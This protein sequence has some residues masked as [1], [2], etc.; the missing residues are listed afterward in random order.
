MF[1]AWGGGAQ[2]WRRTRRAASAGP[3]TPRR[4]RG[5]CSQ[6]FGSGGGRASRSRPYRRTSTRRL[7]YVWPARAPARDSAKAHKPLAFRCDPQTDDGSPRQ[8]RDVPH[9]GCGASNAGRAASSPSAQRRAVIQPLAEVRVDDRRLRETH[10]MPRVPSAT[11]RRRVF[12]RRRGANA[13]MAA[14][15]AAPAAW[16]AGQPAYGAEGDA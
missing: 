5:A 1:R 11:G 2:C 10:L 14:G 7:R 3:A 4:R 15:A 9:E 13:G 12:R 6:P 8:R 16:L